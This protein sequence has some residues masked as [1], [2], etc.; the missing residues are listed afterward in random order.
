MKRQGGYCQ[1]QGYR[2][3]CIPPLQLG[4]REHEH[5]HE[6]GLELGHE[7]DHAQEQEHDHDQQEHHDLEEAQDHRTELGEP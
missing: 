5:G 4:Q 3:Y 7:H 1:Y 2:S 6:H